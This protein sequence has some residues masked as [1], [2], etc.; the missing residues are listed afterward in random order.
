MQP[1]RACFSESIFHMS[2]SGMLIEPSRECF[3]AGSDSLLLTTRDQ[4][5]EQGFDDFPEAFVH[6]IVARILASLNEV[7]ANPH[8]AGLSARVTIRQAPVAD[9]IAGC[10][11]A[12]M[13]V[14][15]DMDSSKVRARASAVFK[16]RSSQEPDGHIY[17]CASLTASVRLAASPGPGRPMKAPQMSLTAAPEIERDTDH[18]ASCASN[19]SSFDHFVRATDGLYGQ[20]DNT[21]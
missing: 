20:L 9:S 5:L 13:L 14:V 18:R 10:S 17:I 6:A 1:D 2:S 15:I 4:S 21:L 7:L 11:S 16:S 12:G 3:G 8:R 19:K